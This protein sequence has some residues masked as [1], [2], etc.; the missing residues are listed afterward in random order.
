MTGSTSFSELFDRH[1][2]MIGRIHGLW[3]FLTYGRRRGSRFRS[4]GGNHRDDWFV[5]N[6]LSMTRI[7]IRLEDETWAIALRVVPPDWWDMRTDKLAAPA[8]AAEP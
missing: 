5:D 4:P 3:Y 6:L 2:E 1:V 8:H 7:A